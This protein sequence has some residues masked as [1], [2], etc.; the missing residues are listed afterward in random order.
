ML[1]EDFLEEVE[2]VLG[3]RG[4]APAVLGDEETRRRR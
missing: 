3:E 4:V 1:L 2:R